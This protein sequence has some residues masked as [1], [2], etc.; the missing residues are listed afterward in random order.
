MFD[1]LYTII[2]NVDINK[3]MF[4]AKIPLSKNCYL[5]YFEEYISRL[6]YIKE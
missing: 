5:I 2:Y 1:H 4:V 3:Y 6:E